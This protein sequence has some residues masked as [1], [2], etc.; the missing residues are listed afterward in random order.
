M[1][2]LLQSLLVFLLVNVKDIVA[3]VVWAPIGRL[4]LGVLCSMPD[5]SRLTISLPHYLWLY[6]AMIGVIDDTGV[7][8]M[9]MLGVTD[10]TSI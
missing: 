3:F 4:T 7:F 10:D 2:C 9:A 5:L 8:S 6:V 1:C